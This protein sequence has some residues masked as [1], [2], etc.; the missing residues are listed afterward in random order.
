MVDGGLIHRGQGIDRLQP[1]MPVERYF[2]LMPLPDIV[3]AV[4]CQPEVLAERNRARGGS[5][6]RTAD[7]ERQWHCHNLGMDILKRR[8]A[9]II[10]VDTTTLTPEKAAQAIL[11]RLGL[12][13]RSGDAIKGSLEAVSP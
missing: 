9:R 3:F 4:W 12:I 10:P 6:D 13:R 7:L 2:E 8:G 11:V 5:H 1:K